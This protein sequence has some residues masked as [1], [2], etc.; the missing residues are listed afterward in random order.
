MHYNIKI[1]LKGQKPI[2]IDMPIQSHEDIKQ[3][4]H[5]V[6]KKNLIES[7]NIKYSDEIDWKNICN[8]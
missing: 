3:F 7:I 4:I 2:L 1:E 6:I 8:N 5:G